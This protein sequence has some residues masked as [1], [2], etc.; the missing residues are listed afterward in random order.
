MLLGLL[1]ACMLG[2]AAVLSRRKELVA[3][4]FQAAGRHLR[5]RNP[6][7]KY[8]QRQHGD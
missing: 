4:S 1:I 5:R 6:N 3:A 8:E 7:Q 2:A